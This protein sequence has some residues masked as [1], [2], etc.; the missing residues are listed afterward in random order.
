MPSAQPIIDIP[1]SSGH[2]FPMTSAPTI[3]R[4]PRRAPLRLRPFKALG[5]FRKLIADKEDTE[6]VFHMVDCLPSARY[7]RIQEAFCVSPAGRALM[8]AEPYLPA[9]LDD[10]DR[11]LAMPEGS[12]AHAYVAFMRAEGLSAAG[13]VAESE[14][15]GR[16]RYNDQVQWFGDRLRDT[17]D[18]IHVLTGYGRDALGEQC[19]LGFS[20]GQYRAGV[21][22]FL[23]WAGG[24][25]LW[26]KVKAD[27]PVFG[28]VGDAVRQ[29]K[30]ST[31]LFAQSIAALLAEPLETARARMGIGEPH[32]YRV[33]HKAYRARGIDP[34]N[35]SGGA[36]LA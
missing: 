27:A 14:R 5:H 35:F 2:S 23:A 28:A 7:R 29:G 33:A 1:V 20:Y 21:D 6:Q 25:E 10:H 17:H 18:L 8:E 12:V 4:D 19:A 24:F 31:P 36:S 16:P 3:L 26:R 30:A 11:L 15:A 34:Y 22:G 32:R 13:L 9:L